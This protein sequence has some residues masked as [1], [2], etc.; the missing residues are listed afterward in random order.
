MSELSDGVPRDG[1]SY[2]DSAAMDAPYG[3][4]TGV[5]AD[6]KKEN[7]PRFSDAGALLSAYL[8]SRRADETSARNRS[9][10]QAMVDGEPPYK[11]IALQAAGRPHATNINFLEGAALV[12]AHTT[13]YN[14]LIDG[15]DVLARGIMRPGTFE[16]SEEIEYAQIIAEEISTLIRDNPEF[17]FNWEYLSRQIATH[18]VA[19]AYFPEDAGVNWGAGGLDDFLIP[20]QTRATEEA[21]DVLFCLKKTPI[22]EVWQAIEDEAIAKAVGWNVRVA[23]KAIV[24]ASQGSTKDTWTSD[25]AEIQQKL[26]NNDLGESC[27]AST[28]PIIHAWVKER[29][30][31]ISHYMV[32]ADNSGEREYLFEKRSRFSQATDA[33][34]IFT[35]GIGNGTYHSI[36]G[37]AYRNYNTICELNKL[38]CSMIDGTKLAMATLVQPGD[39]AEST[40][41]MTIVVNGNTAYLPPDAKI[42]ERG[43]MPSPAQ[44]SMPIIQDLSQ[45]LGTTTGMHKPRP[46]A[47]E[48]SDKTRFELQAQIEAQ[49]SLTTSAV[50]VFYRAFER[51]LNAVLRRV[52]ALDPNELAI[53]RQ[54]PDVL[55]FYSRV[56]AR[57]VPIQAVG[58]MMRLAPIKALG[59]GSPTQRLAAVQGL[60]QLAG[61]FDALGRRTFDRMMA[62]AYVG[63]DMVDALLPRNPQPRSTVEDRLAELEHAAL[64]TRAVQVDPSEL[65]TTHIGIHFPIIQQDMEQISQ[66]IMAGTGD[67][68]AGSAMGAVDTDEKIRDVAYL[69]RA[70]EHVAA[71][72]ENL[73]ADPMRKQEVAQYDDALNQI[74]GAWKRL[75]DQVQSEVNERQEASGQGGGV[76]PEIQA[77][78]Q[79][80]AWKLQAMQETHQLKLAQ[81]EADHQQRMRLRLIQTDVRLSS[82][83][84]NQ[85]LKTYGPAAVK[86]AVMPGKNKQ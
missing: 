34:V 70:L 85:N 11:P 10:V 56:V 1:V 40:D 62:A 76:S 69:Q 74:G 83:I 31:E 81:K 42:V 50:N 36:R 54:H 45:L 65:H 68:D 64:R 82:Q 84:Q 51:F 80:H 26:K 71:H 41:D 46:L 48:G 23:K 78:M 13:A 59:L 15:V 27:K 21:C 61:G 86:P 29:S 32:L 44:F 12:D 22:S 2:A 79:E 35:S 25:W 58:A 77:K 8:E 55:D 53:T 33:F 37:A 52:Q 3:G 66:T 73:R 72:V 17:S 38:R 60:A 75:A 4:S 16:P 18:G 14:A 20:R 57:E 30:G 19:I 39:D 7:A 28:I 63:Y 67:P 5:V 24:K 47:T 43:S 9:V 6:E 49:T